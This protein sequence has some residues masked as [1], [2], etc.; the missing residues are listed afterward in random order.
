MCDTFCVRRDDRMLFAKNSD[1]PPGEVQVAWPFGRRASAAAIQQAIAVEERYIAVLQ[2]LVMTAKAAFHQDGRNARIEKAHI[3]RM[4]RARRQR[5]ETQK[6]NQTV[7]HSLHWEPVY[8]GLVG[9][10]LMPE[11]H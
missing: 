5:G 2:F 11:A 9:T 6:T 4:V 1:R 10:V 7:S 3:R 8:F